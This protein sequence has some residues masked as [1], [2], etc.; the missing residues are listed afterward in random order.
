MAPPPAMGR[1]RGRPSALEARCLPEGERGHLRTSPAMLGLE[2]DGNDVRACRQV[3]G[4]AHASFNCVAMRGVLDVLIDGQGVNGMHEHASRHRRHRWRPILD[5]VQHAG[6]RIVAPAT[7]LELSVIR[8]CRRARKRRVPISS[9][10]RLFL[11]T[12][13]LLQFLKDCREAGR[14]FDDCALPSNSGK[15]VVR[16]RTL[17]PARLPLCQAS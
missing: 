16:V 7:R 11:P 5:F 14:V 15:H 13:S 8:A 4:P 3:V 2:E 9:S 6:W 1:L 10:P 12:A 17:G